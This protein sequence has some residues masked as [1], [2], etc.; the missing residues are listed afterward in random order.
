[1][2]RIGGWL[3]GE[4]A[5]WLVGGMLNFVGFLLTWWTGTHKL[6]DICGCG[7][8]TVM[9]LQRLL[10]LSQRPRPPPSNTQLLLIACVVLWS[11]RLGGFLFLR[12]LRSPEDKRLA[13]FFP[14]PGEIPIKLA[15]FWFI[16]AL[17]SL[18]TM[19]PILTACRV[20]PAKRPTEGS[21]LWFLP[22]LVGFLIE[23]FA[24]HQKSTFKA[25]P[26]NK[27]KF[28]DQGLWYY[29]RHPNYFGEIVVWWSLYMASLPLAPKW[30][31]VSPLFIT[32]LLLRVSGIPILEASYDKKY[33]EDVSYQQYKS[34]TSLLVPM[35]KFT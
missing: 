13:S 1:M 8:F 29:S 2:E 33:G 34:S 32:F 14:K 19:L 10:H 9:A 5:G 30:T 7:A 26:E 20:N 35:P 17:W 22:F 15:G 16:Q 11:I 12:I 25:M 4:E 28:C 27:N 18:I 3:A 23:V 21:K 24:D 6:T 31:I